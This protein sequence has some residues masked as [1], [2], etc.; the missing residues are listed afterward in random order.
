[1][2]AISLANVKFAGSHVGVSIGEDGPSQMALEDLGMFRAIPN[3]TVFY[4]S[5]AVSTEYAVELAANTRY[6]AYIRTSR[7]N[8][9]VIYKNDE[10][11]EI[12]KAKVVQSCETDVATV[13]G[14]G[15]TLHEAIKAS[16]HLGGGKCLR[17]IDPF[18]I[19]PLDWQ[20]IYENVKQTNNRLIVVEDHYREGGIG[21]TL[22]ELLLANNVNLGD[23]RYKHLYVS[24][25]PKSGTPNELLAKYNIDAAAIIR[26]VESFQ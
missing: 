1:M 17:V 14:A 23:L 3:A 25:I 21:E 7:P 16:K 10:Q 18:T 12:G 26:A 4:P 6:I 20:T 19:K 13:V 9:A 24:E 2:G 22:T 5:D 8:T 11:F 15:I